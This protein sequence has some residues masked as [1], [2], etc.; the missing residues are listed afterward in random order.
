MALK[1]ESSQMQ[2]E[3]LQI[4]KDMP[5][6]MMILFILKNLGPQRFSEILDMCE[7]IISRTTVAKYLK[8][9]TKKKYI[10]K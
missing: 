3:I 8:L 1:K 2:D 10:E 5:N 6:D 4:A 9:H 7:G